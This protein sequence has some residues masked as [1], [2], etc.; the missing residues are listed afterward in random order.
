MDVARNP[1]ELQRTLEQFERA[2]ERLE[3]SMDS[4]AERLGERLERS[5]ERS[6]ERALERVVD[7]ILAR[8]AREAV[9]AIEVR[10]SM[11]PL[12]GM[13]S[14]KAVILARLRT[15][16]AEGFSL[17]AMANRF[18]DEGVPTLSGKG[19]WHKGTIGNL[20]AEGQ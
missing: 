7:R 15:M 19:R 3:R 14:E 8:R 6:I 10:P 5:I 18:N 9:P 2:V 11:G 1:A 16:Q 4:M 20:L 12:T 13:P 17:Q